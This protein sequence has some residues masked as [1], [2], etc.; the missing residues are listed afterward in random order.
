MDLLSSLLSVRSASAS[1]LHCDLVVRPRH[2]YGSA[3]PEQ[4]VNIGVFGN[5]RMSEVEENICM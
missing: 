2:R 3:F 1:D 5:F 4:R